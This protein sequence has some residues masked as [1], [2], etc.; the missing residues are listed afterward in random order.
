MVEK[1]KAKHFHIPGEKGLPESFPI[2]KVDGLLFYIQR[3][4]NKN[5]VVYTLNSSNNGRL[6]A[7]Y[8]MSVYWI[9]YNNGGGIK[10]LNKIQ[11]QLAYGY[12][13][14]VINY[15]TFEF[16]LVSYK[17]LT[18]YLAQDKDDNHRVV[19]NINGIQSFLTNIYV[20]ADE[21]GLF[22]EVRYFELYGNEVGSNF[23]NYQRIQL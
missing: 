17:K 20:Y 3:N 16:K 9:R 22:P 14:K 8:P 2:P 4:L 11:N 18:F 23:P 10:Q 6:N 5:T 1:K 19:T 15:T 21:L 12:K 13:S 7:D